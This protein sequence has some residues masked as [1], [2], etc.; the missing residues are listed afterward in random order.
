MSTR[1]DGP[2]ARLTRHFFGGFFDLGFL[3]ETGTIPVTR[4]IIG[5]GATFIAFGLLLARIYMA[6]YAGFSEQSTPDAYRLAL[7]ADHALLIAIPMWIVAFATILVG[8]ALFPDE[9]DFRVLG[10]L[11]ITR[12]LIF[13]S[14]LLALTLFV[15]LFVLFAQAALLP[16]FARMTIS[17]WAEG[18][19]VRRTAAYAAATLFASAFAAL[20][21]V[22]VQGLLLFG[23]ARLRTLAAWATLR[24]AMLCGLML[25]LPL[26]LRLPGQEGSFAAGAPWLAA[27][28]PAWF[29]GLEWWLLGDERPHMRE[30]A[31]LAVLAL[32][33]AAAV[34]A[35]SY[36]ALYRRFDRLMMRPRE[37][38][39]AGRWRRGRRRSALRSFA[40]P[41]LA[42][43][44]AFTFVT[45]RRSEL[46]QG[47]FVVLS[48]VGAGLAINSLI[49]SG[50]PAWLANGGPPSSRMTSAL[51]WAPFALVYV[52]A[53]AARMAL[54]VPIE[55]RANWVFRMTER[56][57]SRAD[58]LE[59]A[60]D[61]VRRLGVIVPVLLVL[62]LQW[63]AWGWLALPAA[64][65]ALAAGWLYTELLMW[66]WSRVP[67]TCSY[68]PAKGFVPQAIVKGVLL[69]LA[70]TTAGA[71]LARA[72]MH[73]R[74]V[75][76][77]TGLLMVA[78]IL[79]LR[80]WRRTTARAAPLEFE[81][82]LPS[83]L[84]PLR[85]SPE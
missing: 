2:A 66:D 41:V 17:P 72:S 16:L 82:A 74:P 70:F 29:T 61:A 52:A 77:V 50:A 7:P 10:P 13:G 22:A 64:A 30:L 33:V 58:Q 8:H 53:R 84:N 37:H 63:H 85:L 75:A 44:R 3:S 81:D 76:L 56:G 19:F 42:A 9:T 73:G 5:V 27:A 46:H 25:S 6:K 4:L 57:D 35:A 20:A 67:F 60:A 49:G 14:K 47:L 68:I 11:P 36:A 32:T 18:W 23:A 79:A 38:A 65:A 1:A 24:S 12:R 59:A 80:H 83:E 71:M 62:P 54:L 26:L 69:F 15:G 43:V 55:P 28:P 34:A 48:A 78:A 21:M 31:A 39:G 45:L 40:R 51:L